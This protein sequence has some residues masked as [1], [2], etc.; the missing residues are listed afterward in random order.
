RKLLRDLWR[1][2]SQAA[3]IALVVACGIGVFVAELSTYDSLQWSR[4][5]YYEDA[6]FAHVFADVK[7][8][9]HSVTRRI[10]EIPAVAEVETTVVFDVILDIPGVVEPVTGRMI[11]LPDSGQPRVNRLYLRQGQFPE[12]GRRNEVL[13]SESFA[14][15]RGLQPGDSL[16]ALINGKREQLTII[17][18]VLSPEYIFSAR[19]GQLPDDKGF[20]VFWMER[21]QLASA[22]NMEGAFNHAAVRLTSG[23]LEP[24][25]VSALDRLL[26]PYGALGAH[27]RT[28]QVSHKI[29]S[30]EIN[31]QKT[32]ASIFPT[33]FLGVAAFLLHVVLSRQVAMQREQIAALKALGYG[34]RTIGWHYLK[35]VLVIVASGILAGVAIGAWLGRYMTEMYTVFFHFPHLVYHVELWIPLTAAVASLGAGVSAALGTMWRVARLA[36]AEAMRPPAPARFRRMLL[37]RLGLERVLSAQARMVIRILERRPLRTLFTT[38]AI[39]SSVAVIVAGTFW[40]DAFDYLISVQ[41]RATQRENVSLAFTD[42]VNDS[43]RYEIAHLPGVLA[44]E[45]SRLVPVRLRAGHRS[46]RTGVLGLPENSELRRLLNADLE[47]VEPPRSGILLSDRLARRL[48]VNPGQRVTVE[49][50][51]GRRAIRELTVA[52]VVS[53]G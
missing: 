28:D 52:G 25:V 45:A 32:F 46:Y 8:A 19:G 35:L 10:A 42:P 23:A 38:F 41:F 21:E 51:E 14:K 9:P 1:I 26:A 34:N 27:G 24:D 49:F 22:Y 31:Q 12:R 4:A 6:R 15:A 29:L 20:G 7:R 44:T 33:I 3:T 16:A 47:Q 11:A 36:P 43:V 48:S 30:Q 40:S 17:G 39:A 50:L 13:V 37:E 5:S 53:R 18:V 2:K